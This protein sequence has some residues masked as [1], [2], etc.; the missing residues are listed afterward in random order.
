MKKDVDSNWFHFSNGHDNAAAVILDGRLVFAAEEERYTRH[1]HSSR[2]APLNSLIKAFAFLGKLNIGPEDVDA[3]AID[4]DPELFPI[5]WWFDKSIMELK[6]SL[7]IDDLGSFSSLPKHFLCW[8][9]HTFSFID[10]AR[11]ILKKAYR[12]AGATFPPETR[13]VRVPH[14]LSRES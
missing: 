1:K 8:T 4:F 9:S 12:N 5:K 11:F 3:F 7:S 14:H 10:V 2:E 13:I 6:S